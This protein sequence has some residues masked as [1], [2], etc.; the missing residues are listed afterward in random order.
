M[1][2]Y[3]SPVIIYVISFFYTCANEVFEVFSSTSDVNKVVNF[4][5]KTE[6]LEYNT[7]ISED[8]LSNYQFDGGQFDS[9][10]RMLKWKLQK[11]LETLMFLR[12]LESH[13]EQS[14]GLSAIIDQY[15]DL[16]EDVQSNTI[17]ITNQLAYYK[18]MS[19]KS[20]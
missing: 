7:N 11:N 3:L 17:D 1:S 5:A 18:S 9:Q 4:I 15:F 13:Y 8:L 6:Q 16:K 14:N 12:E 20:A 2:P 19:A 10:I